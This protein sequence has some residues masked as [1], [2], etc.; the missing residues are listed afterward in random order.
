MR[1]CIFT[2]VYNIIYI[3][4]CIYIYIYLLMELMKQHLALKGCSCDEG[5]NVLTTQWLMMTGLR[6]GMCAGGLDPGHDPSSC[7]CLCGGYRCVPQLL[8][9]CVCVEA[10]GWAKQHNMPRCHHLRVFLN[11]EC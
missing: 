4:V 11:A 2:Y 6:L 8:S 9:I 3:Y 1:L 7:C 5:A 10:G